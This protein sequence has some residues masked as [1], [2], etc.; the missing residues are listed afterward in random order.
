ML[1]RFSF[2]LLLPLMLAGCATQFS[3]L[4]P[5]QQPRNAENLYPVEVRLDTRQRSFRWDSI[6][7]YVIVGQQSY[8]MTQVPL[9]HNRWDCLL[10]VPASTASVQYRYKFDYLYNAFGGPQPDSAVSPSYSLRITDK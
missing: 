2:A 1:K 10:P 6:K 8:P 5:H 7:P 3:N 4:T 9:V